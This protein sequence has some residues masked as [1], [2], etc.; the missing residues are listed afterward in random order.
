VQVDCLSSYFIRKM[1]EVGLLDI[2]PTK[3]TPTW[4][5]KRTGEARISKRLDRFLISE[6][7][8]DEVI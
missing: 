8:L 2:E 7:F 4:R 5:N 1:E 6:G 3:L